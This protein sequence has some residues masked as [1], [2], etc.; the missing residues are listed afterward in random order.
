MEGLKQTCRLPAQTEEADVLPLLEYFQ[1]GELTTSQDR[2][3][4]CLLLSPSLVILG[5]TWNP[6]RSSSWH[7][8]P[9]C[10]KLCQNPPQNIVVRTEPSTTPG[11]EEGE[12]SPP[13]F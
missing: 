9:R 6:D 12:Q 13:F 11:Q 10:F 5:V 4:H 7:V 8:P 2:L 1:G 3:L